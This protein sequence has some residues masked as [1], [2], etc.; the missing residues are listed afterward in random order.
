MRL[1]YLSI[2]KF[3]STRPPRHLTKLPPGMDPTPLHYLSYVFP[4]LL[5]ESSSDSPY[6]LFLLSLIDYVKAFSEIASHR[7]R[8][9]REPN[10][11]FLSVSIT[12]FLGNSFSASETFLTKY[13]KVCYHIRQSRPLLTGLRVKTFSAQS[14]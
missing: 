4:F 14:L 9:L 2:Q 11:S 13:R 8:N 3:Y 5:I 10:R 12:L 6:F 1:V 7:R